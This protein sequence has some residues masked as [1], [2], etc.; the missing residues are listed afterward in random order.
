M[1]APSLP[2]A[3]AASCG[4]ALFVAVLFIASMRLPG[5][6]EYGAH[7]P[8]GCRVIYR[9]NGLF[10][11]LL[12]LLAAACAEL[13]GLR[14]GSLIENFWNL[15]VAANLFAFSLALL[16]VWTGRATTPPSLRSFFY[17]AVRDPAFLGVDLKLFSYRPSLIGL[18]LVAMAC[19]AR[20]YEA[21]GNVTLAMALWLAMLG[22]YL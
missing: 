14:L 12:S 13:A 11:F 6:R 1:I 15:L 3:A 19:A 4:V 9:L 7:R 8:D 22:L 2:G 10:L 5:R 16:L 20:Q 21:T 17:G 18:M